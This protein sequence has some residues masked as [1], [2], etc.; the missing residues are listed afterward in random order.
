MTGP[1]TTAP[2]STLGRLNELAGVAVVGL[3]VGGFGFGL[4]KLYELPV[5]LVVCL[6][7]GL[8]VTSLVHV[9]R[10]VPAEDLGDV[11]P[12]DEPTGVARLAFVDLPRLESMFGSAVSD[13][14]R[15]DTR[16][17]PMF[18]ALA[19][20]LLRQRHGLHWPAHRARIEAMADP[21][22][23]ELLAASPGSVRADRARILAW[24]EC[25]EAL[26]VSHDRAG[27]PDRAAG[28]MTP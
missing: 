17:R 8:F 27:G 5:P 3:A 25:L 6:V 15:F 28:R 10:S 2:V 1:G 21:V 14:E 13:Q 23:W 16:V 26:T 4:T 18:A 22:L 7:T 11:L 20:D 12:G 24:T 9:L 19:T